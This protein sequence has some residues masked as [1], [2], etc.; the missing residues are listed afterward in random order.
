MGLTVLFKLFI[1]KK[2]QTEK[3]R[4]R[5]KLRKNAFDL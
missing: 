4:E 2:K 3:E 1:G 5:K